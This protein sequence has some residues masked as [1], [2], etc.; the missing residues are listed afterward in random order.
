MQKTDSSLRRLELFQLAANLGSV[1]AVA[2]ETGLSISTVS[3]HLNALE[4]ELGVALLNHNRRPMVLTPAGTNFLKHIDQALQLIRQAR[5]EASSG[6]SGSIR[7]LKLGFIED[8]DSDIAPELAVQLAN[9]MPQCNFEHH[10]RL[11][12]EIVDLVRSRK[13]DLG[14][15]NGQT[16]EIGDIKEHPVLR[17]PF[18]LALPA[19]TK[20]T[21]EEFLEGKSSLP[22]LR[23]SNHQIIGNLI[24]AQL[25]RLKISLPHRFEIDSNQTTMAMIAS[26]SGWAITTPLCYIRTRRFHDQ[27]TLHPFPGKGFARY[28]SLFATPECA[29]SITDTVNKSLRHLIERY[30]LTPAHRE[31]PWLQE[32]FRL[33]EP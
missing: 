17:D 6:D 2:S 20:V 24:D 19:Q 7:Q 22:L 14:L 1:Q 4:T 28:I 31:M 23:Y 18:V 10:T 30:A 26:Q 9:A 27:V 11:S 25:R 21:P 5:A 8:F 15:A 3:Y 16:K 32:Q 33:L 12:H 29:G 13:I